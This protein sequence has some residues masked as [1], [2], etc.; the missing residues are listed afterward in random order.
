[1]HR[2]HVEVAGADHH[3]VGLLAGASEPM[4]SCCC[5]MRAPSM[6]TQDS[7]SRVVMVEVGGMVPCCLAVGHV[8]QAALDAQRHARLREHVAGQHALEVDAQRRRAAEL[9]AAGR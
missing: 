9:R 7:A 5:S 2:L 4:R 1:V 8:V 3:Q 6:V